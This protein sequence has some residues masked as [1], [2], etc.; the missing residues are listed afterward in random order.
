SSLSLLHR[1]RVDKIKID[2]SFVNGLNESDEIDALV[3]A[4]V[5]LARSFRL[6]VIAEGVETEEQRRRLTRSGCTEFQG[7]LTGRPMT[8][9]EAAALFEPQDVVLKLA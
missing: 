3:S 4:I 7:F 5:E 6:G 1:F 2:R 8:A 9:A